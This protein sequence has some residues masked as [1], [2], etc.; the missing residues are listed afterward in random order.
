MAQMMNLGSSALNN[1]TRLETLRAFIDKMLDTRSWTLVKAHPMTDAWAV[2]AP[3]HVRVYNHIDG[4]E[5]LTGDGSGDVIL[6]GLLGEQWVLP[7][8][9][10]RRQYKNV[11]QTTFTGFDW[12]GENGGWTHVQPRDLL[13]YPAWAIQVPFIIKNFPVHGFGEEEMLANSTST[14]GHGNGDFICCVGED[15]PGGG[16]VP[17]LNT[18]YVVHHDLFVRTHD[19]SAFPEEVQLKPELPTFPAGIA[20]RNDAMIPIGSPLLG[21]K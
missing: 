6:S 17:N 3:P 21:G 16:Y 8:R 4:T 5:T 1:K 20:V 13:T 9:D 18:M 11:G 15:T 12:S 10:F 19:V 14:E 7:A 2:L